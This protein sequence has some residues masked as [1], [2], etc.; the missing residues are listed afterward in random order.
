MSRVWFS[1]ELET[2]ATY[3]RLARRDGVTL[4][5]TTHDSDLWFDG[6]VHSATPGMVPSAVRRS[7]SF[8]ADSA[9][10]RGAI[11]SDLIS[12]DDLTTGRFDGAM[13]MIGLVDWQ[14]LERQPIY[15]GS[16]GTV[17]QTDLGF[18]AELL[19]RKNDLAL[20][21]VPRTSPTCRAVFCGLGC[22]L[23]SARFT[24]EGS[25]SAQD[26]VNNAVTLTGD[27][28]PA[29]MLG[30]TLR[31]LDGPYAGITMHV[32]GLLG[33]ALVL[34]RAMDDVVPLGTRLIA[35]E[36]CDHTLATC[37]TRFGNALNFQGEPFVPGNDLIV[38]YGLS[39]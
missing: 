24:H 27:M 1:G 17:S 28:T 26:S 32:I 15:S 36:G 14:S 11:T 37:T 21:P 31:W 34:D 35:I 30:G 20:D 33:S 29:Q 13:V 12:A 3:W 38:R 5:F 6:V 10:V 25:V 4:G 2:V 8:D 16:I 22:G 39:Q 19:S 23:S 7:A 18:S 9:E